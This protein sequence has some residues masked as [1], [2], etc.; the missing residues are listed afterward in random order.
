[1]LSDSALFAFAFRRRKSSTAVKLTAS[2]DAETRSDQKIW[3]AAV[4]EGIADQEELQKL[5]D[6]VD[7]E[8]NEAA[9]IALASPQPGLKRCWTLLFA[10]SRIQL[11]QS[12]IPKTKSS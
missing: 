10:F 7:R 3:R 5:K 8:I 4:Q 11:R 12:S 6:E 1:M 9:D 2:L